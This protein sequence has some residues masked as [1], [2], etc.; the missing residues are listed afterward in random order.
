MPATLPSSH[1]AGF[2]TEKAPAKW[3]GDA[4]RFKQ[5]ES[6]AKIDADER[7]IKGG[8]SWKISIVALC[9]LSGVATAAT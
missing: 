9:W 3:K 5:P 7:E 1:L 4:P 6:L 2:Y 8:I